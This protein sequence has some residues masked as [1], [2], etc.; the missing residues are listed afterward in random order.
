M[1][2]AEHLCVHCL[3]AP[4]ATDDHGVP[5]SWY[6]AVSAPNVA[7]MT[8]PACGP[9][10]GRLSRVEDEIRQVLGLCLDPADPRAAGIPERAL[11]AMTPD[12][13]R[14]AKDRAR[15]ARVRERVLRDTFVPQ[16][17]V[18]QLPGFGPDGH[19]RFAVK[20]RA[21]AIRE[22]GEKLVRV[23]T[24]AAFAVYIERDTVVETHVVSDRNEALAEQIAR[25]GRV[26]EVPP[27]V[28]V[29]IARAGDEASASLLVADL[30]GRL[31]L[32]ASTLQRSVHAEM[33]A[34]RSGSRST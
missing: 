9:C 2:A 6:P 3:A 14:D 32:F 31:R 29:A 15:R 20:L 24:W 21:A 1:A 5:A 17:A 10:N 7:R 34:A 19:S 26:F 8:A 27:G 12:H 11:R 4:G 18:G 33:R 13:G 25:S 28:R 22:F 16:S 23:A 30:W